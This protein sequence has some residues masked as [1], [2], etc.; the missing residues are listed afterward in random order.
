MDRD[1]IEY[2]LR[3]QRI[4][5]I[6]AGLSF[7]FVASIL[8]FLDPFESKNNV[9]LALLFLTSLATAINT[10]VNF[11]W[12]FSIKKELL[13]IREVNKLVYQSFALALVYF[14]LFIFYLADE[15]SVINFL[16]TVVVYIFY[17]FWFS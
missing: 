8:A 13:T 1:P 2:T 7:L 6:L 14:M 15:L 16:G 5:L 17:R 10:L 3:M 12:V 11:W 4:M 9:W